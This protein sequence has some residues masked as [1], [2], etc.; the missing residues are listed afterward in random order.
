[1]TSERTGALSGPD[2]TA[3]CTDP[4]RMLP[5]QLFTR[6]RAEPGR[7]FLTEVTGRR[8]TFGST[9]DLVRHWIGWLHSRGVRP[10]DHVATLLPSS[11]DAALAWIALSC[12]GAIEVPINP[13]LT[14]EFLEHVLDDAAPVLCLARPELTET[15]SRCRPSIRVVAVE[16][17][18]AEVRATAPLDPDRI[19][20]PADTSC[21]IYTS[22]T[23]GPAK[24]VVLR[25]AQ[26]AAVIG[27]APLTESDVAYACNPMFHVTGRTPIVTM[28]D[29]GG[30]IVFRERF[31]L[32]AVLDDVRRFGCTTGTMPAGL[33]LSLPS[34]ADDADVPLRWVFTGHNTELN[35]AFRERFQAPGYDCYG[36]T[37]VG[38]PLVRWEPPK[39]LDH[40]WCGRLRPGY[41]ARIVDESGREVPDGEPGE[42]WIKSGSRLMLMDRYL[43]RPDATDDAFEGEWYRTGD[44]LVRE[45]DGEFRFVDRARDTI[46]RM[47]EN[48]SSTAIESVVV[49][50]PAVAAS[51]VVGVPD[52]IAGHE[53][54]VIAEREPGLSLS[55][56]ALYEWISTRI[57]RYALPR[58][59]LFVDALDRTPTGKVRKTGLP[60]DGDVRRAWRRLHR[61]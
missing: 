15:V 4:N 52:R 7:P 9:W 57:P 43:N 47:G 8:E 21:V 29:L 58:F 20:G 36:S 28:S 14:G 55:E 53:V 33:L 18:M 34:R 11:I 40:P 37:E 56:E 35:E 24:G 22:G 23:T 51:A 32:S 27:R 25:W 41:E 16:R 54:M 3:V 2:L 44:I 45:S 46:R 10:G 39:D 31:S 59:V 49:K 19:P 48:I 5:Q 13:E 30:R 1:M 42:L 60:S 26:F 38:F 50:H 6:A 17:D 61:R 12:L